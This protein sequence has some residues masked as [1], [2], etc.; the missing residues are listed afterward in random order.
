[1][2]WLTL[3]S[4]ATSLSA[5]RGADTRGCGDGSETGEVELAGLGRY[6]CGG[7]VHLRGQ[8]FGGEVPHE[9]T[10]FACVAQ[11]VLRAGAGK[12]EDGWCVGERIE[13]AVRREIEDAVGAARGDPAD[14]AR[15]DDRVEGIVR[16]A[17]TLRRLESG[18]LVM[19][20][21]LLAPCGRPQG[22]SGTAGSAG[23]FRSSRNVAIC[24]DNPAAA[25]ASKLLST[26]TVSLPSRKIFTSASQALRQVAD[27]GTRNRGGNQIAAGFSVRQRT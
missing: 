9:R 19:R 13:E 20:A 7:L 14:G 23:H 15:A 21:K 3:H 24:C 12:T 2:I 4:I 8:R 10:G 17:V 26:T 16:E 18:L 1:M 27:G 6:G 25:G 11:R 22:T 5:T